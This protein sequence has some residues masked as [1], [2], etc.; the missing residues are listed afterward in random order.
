MSQ[1][2]DYEVDFYG[3]ARRNAQLLRQGRFAEIDVE[4]IAEELE[5]LSKTEQ[6]ELESYLLVL[7]AQLLKWQYQWQQIMAIW[8][9][10]SGS[11]RGSIMEQ[12]VQI[13][14]L[15]RNNPGLKPH[16][17]EAIANAYPD[18]LELASDETQ[19]AKTTFPEVC[20]YTIEQLLEKGFFPQ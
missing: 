15:L 17:S 18:A 12:R 3:W 7:I 5:S 8:S 19:L 4:H 11:W 9:W 13:A 16:L 6:R 2:S 20:P 10:Q 14:K 1:L